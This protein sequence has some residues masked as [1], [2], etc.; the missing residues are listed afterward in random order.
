MQNLIL[1]GFEKQDSQE[2]AWDSRPFCKDYT[3]WSMILS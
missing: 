1:K 3:I 2:A